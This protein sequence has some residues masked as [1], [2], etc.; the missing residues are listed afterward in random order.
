MSNES[1]DRKRKSETD[2]L[3]ETWRC[4]V[5]EAEGEGCKGDTEANILESALRLS[6]RELR[7]SV[8]HKNI[9]SMKYKGGIVGGALRINSNLSYSQG[10]IVEVLSLKLFHFWC[11]D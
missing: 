7:G 9:R 1:T 10:M 11:L 4:G 8:M 6:P 3:L 5:T 2:Q